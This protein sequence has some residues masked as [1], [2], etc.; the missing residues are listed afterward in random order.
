VVKCEDQKSKPDFVGNK[1]RQFIECAVGVGNISKTNHSPKFV[2][3]KKLHS[4]FNSLFL[5]GKALDLIRV[6]TF[7]ENGNVDL[8]LL[9]RIQRRLTELR[10]VRLQKSKK[11]TASKKQIVVLI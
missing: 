7:Q 10:V 6:E 11:T 8:Q 4:F 2:L 1:G 9:D 3:F 5:S